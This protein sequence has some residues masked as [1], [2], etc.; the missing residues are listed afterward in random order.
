MLMMKKT[1]NLEFEPLHPKNMLLASVAHGISCLFQ[2]LKK[3]SWAQDNI[4]QKIPKFQ[5]FEIFFG[6]CDPKDT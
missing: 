5:N 4:Y 2:I 6:F 3:Q 1:N